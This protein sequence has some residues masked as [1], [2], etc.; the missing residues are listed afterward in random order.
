MEQ[1]EKLDII[2]MKI[3]FNTFPNPLENW[4]RNPDG[5]LSASKGCKLV[6]LDDGSIVSV[7]NK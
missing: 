3:P 7:R 6:E 1:Y 5:T 2:L 4:K